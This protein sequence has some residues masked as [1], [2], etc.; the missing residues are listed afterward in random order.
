MAFSLDNLKDSLIS[1][2][3]YI[4]VTLKMT[5]IVFVI[6]VL[7]GLIIATIRFYKVPAA[8]QILAAF[9][10]IYLGIPMML[11]INV[12]YLIFTTSY[13]GIAEFFHLSTTLRDAN[14]VIVA[15][16]T[17]ILETACRTSET[18]R[19]A[20]KA[21]DKIQ[22]DAGYSIGLT[23]FRTLTRIIIP[24]LVPIVMPSVVNWITGTLKGISMI[25]VIGLYEIMNGALVPCIQTYSYVEGYMAAAIIYWILVVIIEQVC[26][27]VEIRGGK[28]RRQSV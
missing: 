17:L 13:N 7:L 8:S 2:A 24:Q 18:F 26:K 4:P 27:R 28:Y 19:G 16:L 15:Y 23:K 5:V 6:S 11:A 3:Q 1:G 25:S 22:F 21:I 14:Y 20:Y 12:Y 10:T 9:V